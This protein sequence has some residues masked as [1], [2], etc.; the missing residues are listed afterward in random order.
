MMNAM[1][2]LLPFR[3]PGWNV[4]SVSNTRFSV[5]LSG[6]AERQSLGRERSGLLQTLLSEDMKLVQKFSLPNTTI[7]S[8][9]GCLS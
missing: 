7:A 4:S 5:C 2:I 3:R 9:F 8:A 6:I 1:R